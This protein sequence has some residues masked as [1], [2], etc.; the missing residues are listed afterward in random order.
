MHATEKLL[1]T[2]GAVLLG[3]SLC[4]CTGIAPREARRD[5]TLPLIRHAEF[6]A[7]AAA[8]P[9]WV[10]EALKVIT[11]YEAQFARQKQ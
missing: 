5:A 8:A 11:E 7:A 2:L 4:G 1:K 10:A 6:P 3:A 9:E